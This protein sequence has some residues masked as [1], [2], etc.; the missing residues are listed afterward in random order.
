MIFR[1]NFNSSP[2]IFYLQ[3]S[4]QTVV[5][6]NIYISKNNFLIYFLIVFCIVFVPSCSNS[7]TDKS[8]D[9]MPTE[10]IEEEKEDLSKAW[11][12]FYELDQHAFNTTQQE[13]K[14]MDSLVAYLI[15]P[16]KTQKEKAR[17]IFM[18]VASHV[19]YQKNNIAESSEANHIFQQRVASGKGISNLMIALG[20]IAALET[21]KEIGYVKDENHQNGQKFHAVNH[22]WNT[23]KTDGEWGVYDVAWASKFNGKIDDYWFNVPTNEYIFTHLPKKKAAQLVKSKMTLTQ[24]EKLPNPGKH[25]FKLGFNVKTAKRLA[26]S[27]KIKTFAQA[28]PVEI[29][30]K[31]IKAPYL[32]ELPSHKSFTIKISSAYAESIEIVN[33]GGAVSFDK[34]G[35]VFNLEIELNVGSMELRVKGKGMEIFQTFLMY[36]V[37]GKMAKL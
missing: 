15:E 22:T 18:W 25:F 29:P 19:K 5:K 23:I 34:K 4:L 24:F 17:V 2:K 14:N 36:E 8:I 3:H 28:F 10:I 35:N 6:V 11:N 12:N 32:K 26:L 16:C 27:G 37:D 21:K 1:L 30:I 7:G 9:S 20:K 13:E 33:G 31:I